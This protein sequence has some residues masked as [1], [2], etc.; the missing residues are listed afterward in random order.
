MAAH[1]LAGDSFNHNS[2]NARARKTQPGKQASNAGWSQRTSE[3]ASRL[4]GSQGLPQA[5]VYDIG[6][7][8]S[9]PISNTGKINMS[10]EGQHAGATGY[11]G[12]LGPGS[13]PDV[14]I[15]R[16]STR[17]RLL[18]LGEPPNLEDEREAGGD[19]QT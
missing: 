3:V 1:E 16:S 8:D 10:F 2:N 15:S 9:N 13:G 14:A 19:Y 7:V 5:D 4:S 18:H 11:T 12:A 6:A 17:T